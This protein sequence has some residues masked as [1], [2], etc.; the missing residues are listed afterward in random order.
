MSGPNG[1]LVQQRGHE[2][3][4]GPRHHRASDPGTQQPESAE[5]AE[6]WLDLYLRG[7]DFVS[8]EF[9]FGMSMSSIHGVTLPFCK[10]RER[11]DG[12]NPY[13]GGDGKRTV[14]KKQKCEKAKRIDP[15]LSRLSNPHSALFLATSVG[16]ST[17]LC[18]CLS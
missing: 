1:I 2:H 12:S 15:A 9:S 6:I 5:A 7:G 11:L 3:R 14:R 13:F 4:D 8:T 10:R 18:N 16:S 17:H